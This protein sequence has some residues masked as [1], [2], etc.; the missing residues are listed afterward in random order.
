MVSCRTDLEDIKSKLARFKS[1]RKGK[2][3]TRDKLSF[4]PGIQADIRSKIARNSD[5]LTRFLSGLNTGALGRVEGNTE[6]HSQSFGEIL[7]KLDKI[8][9]DVLHKKRNASI[10]TDVNELQ[11]ELIDDNIPEVDVETNG[12]EI[13]KWLSYIRGT[14]TIQD[15]LVDITNNPWNEHSRVTSPVVDKIQTNSA[16]KDVDVENQEEGWTDSVGDSG[17]DSGKDIEGDTEEDIEAEEERNME[18]DAES[19]HSDTK[20]SNIRNDRT[21]LAKPLYQARVKDCISESSS[22]L[23]MAFKPTYEKHEPGGYARATSRT[24]GRKSTEDTDGTISKTAGSSKARKR[25]V[26]V[27]DPTFKSA[28]PS[29]MR[30]E[31]YF[32]EGYKLP[33]I[34]YDAHS[35][36][37]ASTLGTITSGLGDDP[38]KDSVLSNSHATVGSDFTALGGHDSTDT[39]KTDSLWGSEEDTSTHRSV[40]YRTLYRNSNEQLYSPLNSPY[41][42]SKPYHGRVGKRPFNNS[43]ASI[44]YYRPFERRHAIDHQNEMRDTAHAK[45]K[46]TIA[47][48]KIMKV[49]LQEIFEGRKT[50]NIGGKDLS[51]ALEKTVQQGD[52]IRDARCSI[53]FVINVVRRAKIRTGISHR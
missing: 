53:R 36:R 49:T 51:I 43:S 35:I 15:I 12:D 42:C 5:R 9:Q 2:S 3:R 14:A 11:Q 24:L 28:N 33:S 44:P 27:T 37:C 17:E 50:V 31:W 45:S 32:L 7:A 41:S 1:L 39:G 29:T 19:E 30:N 6:Q 8:H 26:D 22:K 46:R 18:P 40:I 52:T 4:T 20:E 13:A 16:E 48:K 21:P 25:Y 38:R 47:A 23:S 34:P 10:L